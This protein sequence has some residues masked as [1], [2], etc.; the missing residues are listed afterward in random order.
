[1][2][3]QNASV[4]YKTSENGFFSALKTTPTL[5]GVNGD[6]PLGNERV[7]LAKVSIHK[8]RFSDVS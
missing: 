7:L 8:N 3:R 6:I 4:K 2:N 5:K 1:M